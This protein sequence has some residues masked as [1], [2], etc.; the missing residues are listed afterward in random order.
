[1]NNRAESYEQRQHINLSQYAYEVIIND[2][3]TFM[4]EKNISGFI[5]RILLNSGESYF[6]D[7]DIKDKNSSLRS[8]PKD[9]TL[10]I[11]LND[12]VYPEYYPNEGNWF[13][14]RLKITQGAYIKALIEDYSRKTLFE[15][16]NIFYKE[17]LNELS[18]YLPQND[19]KT[20]PKGILPIILKDN[21][22][23]YIKPYILSNDYQAPYHYIVCM[24][25]NDPNTNMVPAS[26][27]ISRIKDI[28]DPVTSYGSGK[29]T[30][31][32]IKE[33]NRRIKENGVPYIIGDTLE[34][35]VRV[36][37]Y[38]LKMYNSIIQNRPIYT[39]INKNDDGGAV[40]TF[41]TTT[42]Q[43][44]NYFFRFGKEAFI[45]SPK[46]TREW[47]KERYDWAYNAYSKQ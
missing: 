11:R 38:G 40:L 13:G 15:R 24:A 35:I 12:K 16:E 26:F 14:T 22:K 1:M 41:R 28:K 31:K 7:S 45:I 42:M 2:S 36:T 5:N 19:N 3:M 9:Q 4:E 46:E 25:T 21:R 17:T 8:F 23:F 20:F 30:Q 29:I 10:K 34:V 37:A 6:D 33:L 39:E 47:M 32:D 44:T 18:I 43:I 27:R